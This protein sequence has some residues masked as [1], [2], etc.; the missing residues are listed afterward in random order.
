MRRAFQPIG[1]LHHARR[2]AAAGF[3]VFN[4]T[5]IVIETLRAEFGIRKV[6]YIDIDVH[7]GDGVFYAYEADPDVCIVDLHQDGRTLYPGT[8]HAN[9]RGKGAAEGT[10][11]NIPLSP[12]AGDEVFMD[13]WQR[14]MPFLRAAG[15]EFIVLQ[16][17]ADSIAGDPLA[18]LQLSAATHA[19]VA[20]DLC[21]LAEECAQGRIMGFGGGGYNRRNLALGWNGVLKAFLE[22]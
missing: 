21:A 2:D 20:Q 4:D 12:G 9:E 16:C 15:P 10:K 17:G 11:L 3:C 6:A 22:T 1:G 18:M 13:E 5:G 8:G 7:H 19:R 14:A